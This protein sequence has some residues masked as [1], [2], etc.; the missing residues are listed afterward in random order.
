MPI[1]SEWGTGQVFWSM[2]WFFLFVI[3]IWLLIVVFGDIFRSH[4]LSGVAKALWVIFVIIVPYLGVLV[5]LAARGHK[6]GEHAAVDMESKPTGQPPDASKTRP[7]TSKK[8]MMIF[9]PSTLDNLL[10]GWQLHICRRREIHELTAWRLQFFSY[11]LGIPTVVFAAIAGSSAF[12]VWN[13]DEANVALAVFGGIVGLLAAVLASVQTFLDPGARAEHHRLSAVSDKKL[14]RAFERIPPS[15]N[16]SLSFEDDSE[17]GRLLQRIQAE[18]AETDSGAPEAAA[19]T[20]RKGR[21]ATYEGCQAGGRVSLRV[22]TVF[23]P[24]P[25]AAAS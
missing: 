11:V 10:L 16:E 12:V 15:E 7:D 24:P 19:T 5:Y 25:A 6:I 20:R 14:A 22:T 2:L 13:T 3:W 18:L 23:G 9:D 1:I 21:A 8:E 17:D 4:D